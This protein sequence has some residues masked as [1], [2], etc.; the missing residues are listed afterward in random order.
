VEGPRRVASVE[1][2]YVFV[3]KN[4]LKKELK[5]AHATRLRFCKDKEFNVTAELAQAA[6][7]NNHQLYFVSKILDALYNEKEMFHELLLAWRGFPVGKATWKTVIELSRRDSPKWHMRLAVDHVHCL[8]KTLFS[9]LICA[10][11]FLHP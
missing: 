5:D 11:Y 8:P 2:D 4:L 3:V 6:E 10:L 9:V 7:H 1:S